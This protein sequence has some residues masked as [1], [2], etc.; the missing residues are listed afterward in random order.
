MENSAYGK[1]YQWTIPPIENFTNGQFH[2]WKIPPIRAPTTETT[3]KSFAKY[4]VDANL[5]RQV[6]TNLKKNN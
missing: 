3:Y 6:S 4:A 2:L 1:L 5:F